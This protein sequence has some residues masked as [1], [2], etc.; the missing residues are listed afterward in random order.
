MSF[1]VQQRRDGTPRA[2]SLVQG[3]HDGPELDAPVQD[4]HDLVAA[5][6]AQALQGIGQPGRLLGK[7][8]E[9][10]F[11]ADVGVVHVDHGQAAGI[12]PRGPEASTIVEGEFV[13]YGGCPGRRSLEIF[14]RKR[15]RSL[16]CMRASVVVE[17]VFGTSLW[18]GQAADLPPR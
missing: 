6:D 5:S 8:A 16:V 17:E 9:G 3:E 15:G 1:D 4:D 18:R 11:A 13:L 14:V 10:V 12:L 7:I 2:P